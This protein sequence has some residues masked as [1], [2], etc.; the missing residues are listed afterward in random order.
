MFH[1]PRP[2]QQTAGLHPIRIEF[3]QGIGGHS[4]SLKLEKLK[5][6]AHEAQDGEFEP[7]Y[8]HSP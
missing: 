1:D 2:Y 8:S 4:L 7:R 3:F 5:S 6:P